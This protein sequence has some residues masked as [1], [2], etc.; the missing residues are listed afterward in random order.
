MI[1]ASCRSIRSSR[2]ATSRTPS[3]CTTRSRTASTPSTMRRSTPVRCPSTSWRPTW[4]SAVPRTC[5]WHTCPRICPR[6]RRPHRFPA[7]RRSSRWTACACSTAGPRTPSPSPWRSASMT[8][9][10]PRDTSRLIRRWSSSRSIVRTKSP[11]IVKNLRSARIA[12]TSSPITSTRSKRAASATTISANSSLS[13][14]NRENCSS[15]H[16]RSPSR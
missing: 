12:T 5:A 15:S 4:S 8:P 9:K 13:W 10:L 7:S 11:W 3:S 14:R 6:S 2:T 1:R 16:P